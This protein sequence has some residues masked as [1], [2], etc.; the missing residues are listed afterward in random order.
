VALKAL[1]N[2]F[3]NAKEYHG[4]IVFGR[5][6]HIEDV[7]IYTLINVEDGK[8][9]AGLTVRQTNKQTISQLMQQMHGSVSRI[10]SSKDDAIKKQVGLAP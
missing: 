5:F 9:L 1:G 7:D 8:N 6:Q 3:T 10:K 4:K 2:A